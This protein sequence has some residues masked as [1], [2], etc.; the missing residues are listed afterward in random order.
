MVRQ[1]VVAVLAEAIPGGEV[2]SVAELEKVEGTFELLLIDLELT[3]GMSLNWLEAR[4]KSHHEK[5]IILSAV[6][7]DFVLYRALRS[8]VMG[9]VHKQDD[10]EILKLAVQSVLAG[11]IFFSPRMQSLR[12]RMN[13]DPNCFVKILSERE[14]QILELIGAGVGNDEAASVLG[15]KAATVADH[16]KNIMAKLD[17]HSQADL[18]QYA[19][20]KGFSRL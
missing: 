2:A 14:Q 3:D 20:R 4:T 11:S 18:M 5:A 7:E 16:R 1:L 19:L 17:L 8:S 12:Q 9:Y 10:M 6:S 13:S 15:L